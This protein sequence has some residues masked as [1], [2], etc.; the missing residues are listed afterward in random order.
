MKRFLV[1][2]GNHYYPQ[3]GTNDLVAS[4]ETLKEVEEFI[5]ENSYRHPIHG[6]KYDWIHYYDAKDEMPVQC[7]NR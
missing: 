3:G 1:F 5:Y 4:F 6:Y 7:V 2:A